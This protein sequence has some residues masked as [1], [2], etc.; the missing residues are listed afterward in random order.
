MFDTAASI[1][2]ARFGDSIVGSGSTWYRLDADG[3]KRSPATTNAKMERAVTSVDPVQTSKSMSDLLVRVSNQDQAAFRAVFDYFA[4]R[5]KAF[6]MGQGTSPQMAEEVVQE[7]MVRIWRK[8]GQYDPARAAAST[9]IFT[10]A[11]N[12]RIDHLRKSNRPEPDMNDPAFVPDPEPLATETISQAQDSA[13]LYAAM[14][15]LSEDQRAVL[16]LSYFEEKAHPEIAEALGIPL[17][18]V[19]SRIRLA[20]KSIRSRIGDSE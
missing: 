10:I 12:M 2:P 14:A 1:V 13:Q 9:W 19:K 16:K 6:L 20:L 3:L 4:P 18:T 7:T 17:G 11:R 15:E 8:A 5:L